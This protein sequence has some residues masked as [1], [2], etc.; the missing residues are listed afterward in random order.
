LGDDL[1]ARVDALAAYAKLSRAE[2]I[3]RLVTVG[4]H[5]ARDPELNTA[6]A[7]K[8]LSSSFK[9]G[10]PKKLPPGMMN[11]MMDAKVLAELRKN[12]IDTDDPPPGWPEKP[13]RGRRTDQR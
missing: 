8:P 12:R 5:T 3:R 1:L 4:L 7:Q 6:L 13:R 9:G 2:V 10:K 11:A